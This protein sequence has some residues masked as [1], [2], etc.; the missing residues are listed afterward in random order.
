MKPVSKVIAISG[1]ILLLI[2]SATSILKNESSS[3]AAVPETAANVEQQP[4]QQ[5][6]ATPPLVPPSEPQTTDASDTNE[7]IFEPLGNVTEFLKKHPEASHFLE[8]APL[9]GGN[10]SI[11]KINDKVY[12]IFNESFG[13]CGS[14]GCSLNAFTKTQTGYIRS[15]NINTNMPF[16]YNL[17]ANGSINFFL[18]GPDGSV[19]KWLLDND[20]SAGVDQ[21]YLKGTQRPKCTEDGG[22]PAKVDIDL[23]SAGSVQPKE[24]QSAPTA[25]PLTSGATT[26][27]NFIK[28][29]STDIA[30][31]FPLIAQAMLPPESPD[32]SEFVGAPPFPE[33]LEEAAVSIADKNIDLHIIYNNAGPGW[34]TQQGL[35][36]FTI[37]RR[38]G[39][40]LNRIFSISATRDS[41]LLR[42]E[43]SL[44][45]IACNADGK[46]TQWRM[47]DGSLDTPIGPDHPEYFE[48]VGEYKGEG[49]TTTCPA[50][51]ARPTALPKP[52]L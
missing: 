42:E 48:L 38:N 25:Q 10:V 6:A 2:M 33:T 36:E 23:K 16:R 44:S 15:M 35:C 21:A 24:K 39:S 30:A 43:G 31:D 27:L 4:A 20:G 47:T 45:V 28:R 51:P 46:Y 14:L 12:F 1:S 11:A 17:N 5:S 8:E 32:G 49:I 29:A 19:T 22:I 18:C 34:C 52:K 3:H 9:D 50:P 13:Y 37:Y 40:E 41:Y 7:L 26:A